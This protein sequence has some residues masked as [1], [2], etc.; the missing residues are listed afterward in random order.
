ML[1]ESVLLDNVK[2]R[3]IENGLSLTK[4]SKKD[5]ATILAAYTE[6]ASEIIAQTGTFKF[7][8]VGVIHVSTVKEH[9]TTVPIKNTNERRSITVQAKKLA[10]FKTDPKLKRKMNRK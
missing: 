1:R 10:Y 4:I 5:I 7:P 9:G 8:G 3:A 2:A 6:E